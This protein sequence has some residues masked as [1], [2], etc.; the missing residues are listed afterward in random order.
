MLRPPDDEKDYDVPTWALRTLTTL[1]MGEVRARWRIIAFMR[2]MRHMRQGV[3]LSEGNR[4]VVRHQ[5]RGYPVVTVL[6]LFL[7]CLIYARML[8]AH[9]GEGVTGWRGSTL[10]EYGAY[11]GPAIQ[12]GQWWRLATYN[13]LHIGLWHLGFNGYALTQLGP[14]I[15]EVFGRG[16]TIFFF[17]MTGIVAGAACLVWNLNGV[18]AGASGALMGLIGV[19]AAWGQRAGGSGFAVRDQMVKWALYTMVFGYFIH[20][21]NIA[22][23]A[24]FVAGGILGLLYNPARLADTKDS[25]ASKVLGAIGLLVTVACFV[26]CMWPS[27][28]G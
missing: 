8:I 3:T 4:R 21:N 15:E 5:L 25:P 17:V 18:S 11:Y 13:F 14:T 26:L 19:A 9:P 23:A 1:G 10:L 20:A 6:L 24:G 27:L 28:L 2:R 22:H 16:R 7:C 12:A